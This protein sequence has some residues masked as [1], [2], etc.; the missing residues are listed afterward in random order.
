MLY[1]QGR[2]EV[3]EKI[4]QYVVGDSKLPLVLFG[5]SGCGKTSLMAKAASQVRVESEIN[6]TCN[7]PDIMCLPGKL[8]IRVPNIIIF[9]VLENRGP[10]Q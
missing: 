6:S 2:E 3:V 8:N 5:E 10:Y 4:H 1:I 7:N 9:M